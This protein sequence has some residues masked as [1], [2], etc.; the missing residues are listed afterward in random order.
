MRDWIDSGGDPTEG[1]KLY[2]GKIDTTKTPG[3]L[4]AEERA[5]ALGKA[6]GEKAGGVTTTD[7]E[8]QDPNVQRKADIDK[9]MTDIQSE[10]NALE[11]S[12]KTDESNVGFLGAKEKGATQAAIS[13]K[14]K[15]IA[16]LRKRKMAGYSLRRKF[17]AGK[18][19]DKGADA[20]LEK[21][22]GVDTEGG[23]GGEGL[24]TGLTELAKGMFGFRGGQQQAASPAAQQP[25]R[26]NITPAKTK[27]YKLEGVVRESE[28]PAG[29]EVY[30]HPD[31]F[32]M[33]KVNGKWFRLAK[34]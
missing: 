2:K 18:P 7:K 13:S 10:I 31:G 14:R 26:A 9:A 30:Q 23:Q 5:K 29:T 16:E 17:E 22:L 15:R 32:E 25:Q 8:W 19:V 28:L 11:T 6:E 20:E 4:Q 24:L 21:W 27:Q 33:V 3:Q 34:Q 1:L 12:A